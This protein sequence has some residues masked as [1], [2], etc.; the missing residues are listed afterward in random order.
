MAEKQMTNGNTAL[1]EKQYRIITIEAAKKSEKIKLRVAAYIRVSSD[2]EDQQNSF[3]AQNRYYTDLI[4][5]KEN[6]SLVDIYADDTVIL[7]LN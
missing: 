1:Q 5:G 2:S 3:V 7:G 6:W 4:A